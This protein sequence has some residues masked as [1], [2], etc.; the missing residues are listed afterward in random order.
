MV[1][2]TDYKIAVAETGIHPGE[3]HYK[4]VHMP[5][6]GRSDTA[7]VRMLSESHE[8]GDRTEGWQMMGSF[9]RSLRGRGPASR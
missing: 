6:L 9:P 2:D 8:E 3:T 7:W 5:L 4:R 1:V